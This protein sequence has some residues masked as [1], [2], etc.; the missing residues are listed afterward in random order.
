[1]SQNFESFGI[2]EGFEAELNTPSDVFAFEKMKQDCETKVIEH[3]DKELSKFK[4]S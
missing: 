4:K 2:T 1:M 3:V